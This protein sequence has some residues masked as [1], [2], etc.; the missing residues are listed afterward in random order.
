MTSSM[1]RTFDDVVSNEEANNALNLFGFIEPICKNQIINSNYMKHYLRLDDQNK[2]QSIDNQKKV[3]EK[4]K[5][6]KKKSSQLNSRKKRDTKFFDIAPENC[7]YDHYLPLNELWR[8]YINDVLGSLQGALILPKLIKADLHGAVL[9]VSRSVCPSLIGQ[10]GIVIQETE[11]TFKIIT[12]ENK[13]N[14]TITIRVCSQC[15][16]GNGLYHSFDT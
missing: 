3:E 13:V 8:Q 7:I 1:K 16:C 6:A 15:G 4:E 10:I 12:K 5:K 9:Q 11:N 2:Q 14:E